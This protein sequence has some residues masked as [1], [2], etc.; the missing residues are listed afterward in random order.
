MIIIRVILI[1]TMRIIGS[2]LPMVAI[3]VL[4]LSIICPVL[5]VVFYLYII[6]FSTLAFK[7]PKM[8]LSMNLYDRIFSLGVVIRGSRHLTGLQQIGEDGR[9]GDY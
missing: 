4:I 1:I 5:Y 6:M 2:Y 3:L 7:P 9:G 8:A